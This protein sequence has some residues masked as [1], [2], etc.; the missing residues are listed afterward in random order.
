MANPN[1]FCF[2]SECYIDT[3]LVETL[4]G[5][6]ANHQNGCNNVARRMRDKYEDGFAVGIIDDDKRKLSYVNE[7]D[8]IGGSE[9]LTLLK[10]KDRQHYII[11]VSPATEGFILSCVEE[12]GL[13]LSEYGFS[14]D[15]EEFKK[16]TKSPTSQKDPKFKELFKALADVTEM[17]IFGKVLRYLNEQKYGCD[18][19]VLKSFFE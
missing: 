13:N 2:I 16:R 4:L 5:E 10:H 14:P 9:H 8:W 19:S 6:R 3:N 15:L 17:Q 18:E 11:K 1:E 7:F 12:K